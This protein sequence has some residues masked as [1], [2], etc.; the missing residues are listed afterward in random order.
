MPLHT[1][2][3]TH[4]DEDCSRLDGSHEN[5]LFFNCKFDRL[6]GLTLKDCELNQSEFETDSISK[7]LGF[8]MTLG[9]KSFR[10]VRLSSLLFDLVLC[11]LTMGK[12]NDSKREKLKDVVGRDRYDALMRVLRVTE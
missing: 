6:V 1:F 5:G 12:G 8:T 7:A 4:I 3:E 11:L 2:S 9:C 10:G